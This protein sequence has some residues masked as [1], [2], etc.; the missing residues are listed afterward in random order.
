MGLI[1]A[2][3][4]GGTKTLLGRF[5]VRDGEP[6]PERVERFASGE[7]A[8]LEALVAAFLGDTAEPVDAACLGVAG[9]VV[10]GRVDA[11]NL[12]WS[13]SVDE[14]AARFGWRSASLI[15]DLVATAEGLPA[16]A[17]REV[18]ELV[19]GEACE[20]SAQL[21]V[22]AGTGFGAALRVPA[23]EAWT[24]L[25][26]E[27]GHATFAPRGEEQEGLARFLRQR[28]GRVSVER[29]VS[30]PGIAA[31]Y[32]YFGARG[33]PA[34][35]VEFA[36]RWV[37]EDRPRLVTEYA[38]ERD[39]ARARAALELFLSSYGAA[40]G[41][42]ALATLALGGVWVGGGIAAKLEPSLREGPFRRAFLGEGRL[43]ELVARIPVRLVR[44]PRTA[45]QGAARHA[46][47]SLR[48]R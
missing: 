21:V 45:L 10:E 17:A 6:V 47:R 5:S 33:L 7:H 40:A 15:N 39:S 46:A 14:L 43:A 38:L 35:G 23:G 1:L 26:S 29:V 13:V 24:C 11:T 22:A 12:P 42:L 31:A 28:H 37:A 18:T 41:D 20:G 48:A 34:D 8:S 27:A 4:V 30:G 16:L 9:P 25:P 3:D 36:R 44:E 32:E 19:S 2:G